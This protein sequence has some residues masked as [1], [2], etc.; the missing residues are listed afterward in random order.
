MKNRPPIAYFI[1]VPAALICFSNL[2]FIL[3]IY[4]VNI[5]S[6]NTINAVIPLSVLIYM[7][8]CYITG[9]KLTAAKR[10][11]VPESPWALYLP[12]LVPFVT[13]LIV[14]FFPKAPSRLPFTT[15]SNWQMTLFAVLNLFQTFLADMSTA[16]LL[17]VNAAGIACFAIGERRA[18]KSGSIDRP[19]PGIKFAAPAVIILA[20]LFAGGEYSK[21]LHDLSTV[22]VDPSEY[23]RYI[24]M[25]DRAGS[26]EGYGFPYE[27][28]LSSVDLRPYYVENPEN[29]LAV[30]SEPSELIISDPDKMPVLD[31]AEAAY[32]VYSAI[33]GACYENIGEIQAAAK[34]SD[35]ALPMPVRFTNTIKAYESLISGDVD[36]FFGAMPSAEQKK[37]AEEAGKTLVMTPIGKEAFVFFVSGENPVDGL[38]SEQIRDI[39]SGKTN[40]WSK[41][42]GENIPILAFQRPKNSGSQ[43]MM[44]HFMGDIPLKEPLKVEFEQSMI[45]VITAVADYQNKRSSIG[46]SFRYYASGMVD[47]GAESDIKFLSLDG[48]YP[49]TAAIQSG[50]YPMTTSLYAIYL[51]ENDNENVPLLAGFMTGRQGQEIIEKTGYIPAG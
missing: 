2:G 4:A 38:T 24:A 16:F 29:K 42:G 27:N 23:D 13:G 28:G 17:A 48:I 43:T 18:A 37:L 50:E 7:A 46:Y 47:E 6:A 45:G 44:E 8:V 35:E 49:D 51:E 39:Y 40:N 41:L 36:I 22:D 20:A 10:I 14:N 26:Q 1:A 21:Y 12:T 11:K 5:L 9:R 34:K 31:G 25:A 30:L 32:P 33:A 3:S 19:L 15:F